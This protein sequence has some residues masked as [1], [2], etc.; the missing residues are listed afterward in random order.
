[1]ITTNPIIWADIPDPSVIRVGDVYYMTS[2]TMYFSPGCPVMKSYDLVNWEIVN[3]VYDILDNS[4]SFTLSNGK[5]AYGQGSWA[6]SLRYHNGT[7]YVAF[8]AN[9]TGKTYIF[10]TED[11]ENGPWRKYVIDGIYHDMSLLFDDDGRVY[12]VYGGGTIRVIELTSGATAIKL[13]GLNTVIIENA[14]IT[15]EGIVA[16]GS[17]IYKFNGKYYIFIICWSRTGTSRRIQTCYVAE[18]I[19]GSY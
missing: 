1:M 13:G 7:F 3:Y 17:H 15:G 4:D 8:T 19:D 6:S 11:I 2:T 14:H 5:S 16:E 10:Q 18:S 12:M 9:N